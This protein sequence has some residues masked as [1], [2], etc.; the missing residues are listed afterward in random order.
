MAGDVGK[1]PKSSQGSPDH[2]NGGPGRDLMY[3]QGGDDCSTLLGTGD[4]A[5]PRC[6]A[7]NRI[8]FDPGTYRAQMEGGADADRLHGGPGDDRLDGGP[9]GGNAL[10]GGIGDYDFCS[11]G[12]GS[13]D[14]RDISCNLPSGGAND[15]SGEWPD[16]DWDLF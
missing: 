3:G 13:G 1:N 16:W 7:A 12:P 10:V 6:G 15:L 11:F 5:H 8:P 14:R 4:S 2:M 9:E